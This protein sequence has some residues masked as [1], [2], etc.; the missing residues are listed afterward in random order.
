MLQL[1]LDNICFIDQ[2]K[3]YQNSSYYWGRLT[4]RHLS[5]EKLSFD[6]K[7]VM[8]DNN[9]NSNKEDEKKNKKNPAPTARCF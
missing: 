4:L 1:S 2:I 9:N 6:E 5:K 3:N 8:A 7:H